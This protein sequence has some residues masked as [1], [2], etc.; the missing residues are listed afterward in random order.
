MSVADGGVYDNLGLETAWQKCRLIMVSDAG[1]RLRSDPEPPGDWARDIVR[2][3]E[4]IDGQVRELRRRQILDALR[5]GERDGMYVGIGSNLDHCPVP[6]PLPAEH[7]VTRE[8]AAVPTRLCPMPVQTRQQLVNWG[9]ALADG[10]LRACVEPTARRGAAPYPAAR[11][12]TPAAPLPGH[13]IPL[14]A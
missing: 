8:L 1:G 2:V 7:A 5:T 13:G 6:D 10:W 9:H 14:S 4:V 11:L 3:L 12:T